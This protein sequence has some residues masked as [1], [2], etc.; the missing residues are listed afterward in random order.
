MR[1]VGL[2]ENSDWQILT[3]LLD[4][5]DPLYSTTQGKAAN[6]V[7]ISLVCAGAPE[8]IQEHDHVGGS[9][10]WH[11]RGKL[12]VLILTMR[13]H[14]KPIMLFENLMIQQKEIIFAVQCIRV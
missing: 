10:Q 1:A 14:H 12:N 7:A 3:A 6:F 8:R 13:V 9:S 2:F 5:R 4:F 11:F